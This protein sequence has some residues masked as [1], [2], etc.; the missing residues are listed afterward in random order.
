MNLYTFYSFKKLELFQ[1][2][3][4]PLKKKYSSSDEGVWTQLPCKTQMRSEE[5]NSMHV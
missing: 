4:L 3:I 2:N 5:G 1:H